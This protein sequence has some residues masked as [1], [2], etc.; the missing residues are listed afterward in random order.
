MT[1]TFTSTKPRLSSSPHLALT[2]PP[3]LPIKH[4][5]QTCHET[6]LI[7]NDNNYPI[8]LP[9][10]GGADNGQFVYFTESISLLKNKTSTNIIKGGK[11]DVDEI[12]LNIDEHKVAGCTLT[13]VQALIETL[14]INGKQIILKTVRSGMYVFLFFSYVHMDD[15][16]SARRKI[17]D[18][19]IRFVM[20]TRNILVLVV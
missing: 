12:I 4:W 13:D 3:V 6:I 11:I 16:H 7:S 8:E 15:L 1:S 20:C 9:L 19:F 5:S 18:H 10:T 17:V 2:S 14:S